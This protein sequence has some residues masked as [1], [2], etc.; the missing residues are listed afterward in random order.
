MTHDKYCNWPLPETGMGR[1]MGGS[2]LTHE[3]QV[4]IDLAACKDDIEKMEI[5]D[6]YAGFAKRVYR[7]SLILLTARQLGTYL[8]DIL[9]P[10]INSR[11]PEVA[12]YRRGR[13]QKAQPPE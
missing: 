12:V 7:E 13:P 2:Q 6:S 4:L 1:A 3:E 5:L 8:S 10:L 11:L 9:F